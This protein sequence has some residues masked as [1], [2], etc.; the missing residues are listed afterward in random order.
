MKNITNRDIEKIKKS[1]N[2]PKVWT[3]RL[4]LLNGTVDDPARTGYS[5]VRLD[6]GGAVVS[7][8]RANLPPTW[9][10]P[11]KLKMI[12]GRL[13]IYERRDV[14]GEPPV[15]PPIREHAFTHGFPVVGSQVGTG[16]DTL[17]VQARQY[18]PL[19]VYSMGSGRK[20]GI[21]QGIVSLSGSFYRFDTLENEDLASH[22]PV[23]GG[24]F[25]L[26]SMRL[27]GGAATIAYTDGTSKLI[28]KLDPDA[29]IPDTPAGHIP[30]AAVRIYVGQAVITENIYL[31]DI[32]DLRQWGQ[33]GS[34]P[35][36]LS[37]VDYIDFNTAWAGSANVYGRISW[38]D[39]DKTLNVGS[40]TSTVIQV[41]QEN[42]IRVVN[43][44][45]GAITD[46]QVLIV[47]DAQGN[48]PAV[49]LAKAD[50]AATAHGLI[51]VAT[52]AIANNDE[53]FATTQG[54]VRSV[55]T[56]GFT[57]GDAL[58][59]SA[60]TAGAL[61]ATQPA[62]PN[63]SVLVGYALNSTVNGSIFVYPENG[64]DLNELDNVST[65][66]ATNGQVL[67]YNS[68]TGIWEPGTVSLTGF[69]K[70]APT[71]AA[72][73]TIVPTGN[74]TG[75]IVRQPVGGTANIV[76]AQDSSSNPLL[77]LTG[78]PA[79]LT[80][81]ILR[82]TAG[83]FAI[84]SLYNG[85]TSYAQL[86]VSS[87]ASSFR[88]IA[89][90][91]LGMSF[92][93]LGV[94]RVFIC[95]T[96]GTA[97][98]MG[99][100]ENNALSIVAQAFIKSSAATNRV[101]ILKQAAAQSVNTFETRDSSDAVKV[102]I[103]KDHVVKTVGNQRAVVTKTANYTATVNDDVIIFNGTSLTASLPSATG[104]GQVFTIKNINSSDLTVDAN[105]SETI[106]GELTQPVSQWS[107]IKIVDYGTGTWAII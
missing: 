15:T 42:V 105:A 70:T 104:T 3:G 22:V 93:T 55:N 2:R 50:A 29:D 87:T 47:N 25:V 91:G 57:D 73:N 89:N 99:I 9:N 43:K 52:E 107:A 102:Q 88:V 27:S 66:G 32:Y 4:G 6:A 31:T 28:N 5:Y 84:F 103:T 67:T 101:M 83:N 11:V 94:Q 81:L 64:I 71:S 46:G 106:D 12:N 30:L 24:R 10:D 51:C 18:M 1:A 13:T 65:S 90:Q 78:G 20:I 75:L 26:V 17:Y 80:N 48:R 23:T 16:Y 72:D 74:F 61:T 68:G 8:Y 86:D 59:L 85:T 63:H 53:G 41:G 7:A 95:G 82:A 54:I 96:I 45:G 33:G 97:G 36:I 39:T 21:N 19:L 58:Y 60:T 79:A 35:T 34:T 44:S 14:F 100:G 49:V 37:N 40:S 38:N 56:S 77:Y 92:S 76:E 69:V 62:H 98:N